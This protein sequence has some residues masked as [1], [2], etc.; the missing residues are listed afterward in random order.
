M[1]AVGAI[2]E[3]NPFHNGHLWHLIQA[4]AITGCPYVI[5]VMS[6]NFVQRGEPAILD[7]W[8]R[9]EMAV[10]CGMDLVL[11]LPY[12]YAVRSAQYFAAG[13]V[14]LLSA[15]GVV[16]HLC[17]GAEQ[18][19]LAY[20]DKVATALAE[21]K[22]NASIVRHL[23]KGGTYAAALSTAVEETGLVTGDT[24][25][26]PNNILA[27]EY[28]R[29]IK[30]Y[31]PEL[32]PVVVPR[33][34]ANYHDRTIA[35][36]IA[37]ATAIRQTLIAGPKTRESVRQAVPAAALS[38]LEEKLRVGQGP[39][40]L[41]QFAPLL[42]ARLRSATAQ[43][44]ESLPDVS[45][46]LHY[47]ILTAAQTA[48]NLEEVIAA[49]KSKRYTRTRLQR[50]LI[51][52]LLGVTKPDMA[53]FDRTGPLYARVLAFNDQGR[54]LLKEIQRRTS[55]PVITKTTRFLNSHSRSRHVL[56]DLQVMLAYDT[57]ATDLYVLGLPNHH[58]RSGGWDFRRSPL[59]IAAPPPPTAL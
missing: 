52:A 16:T 34:A 10:R 55:I 39:V 54:L 27:I 47:K 49:I 41:E 28:L 33:K 48:T 20:L 12:V 17:F 6:G 8:T 11:E 23:K 58:Y 22:V 9:A 51:H 21:N 4:R 2:V 45:E 13:A 7:K 37:S 36:P 15:L 53:L 31:A 14:R 18:A 42:L 57:L 19:D 3:Y 5:G 25:K 30:K 24:L 29:A 59:Y 40:T 46:G 56:N 38:L 1:Q 32:A 44:L 35:G 50:I 43:W 26:L